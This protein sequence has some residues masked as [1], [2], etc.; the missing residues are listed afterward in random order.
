MR[1]Y[2]LKLTILIIY[3]SSTFVMCSQELEENST[4]FE[5][6]KLITSTDPGTDTGGVIPLESGDTPG[7]PLDD[8]ILSFIVI[9]AI[10]G[11][12]GLRKRIS[13]N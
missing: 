3:L 13:T 10:I 11:Y 12:Y 9:S 8:W 1:K 6:G 7:A 4:L 2:V 5:M